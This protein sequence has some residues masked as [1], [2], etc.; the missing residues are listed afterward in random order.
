MVL[1]PGEMHELAVGRNAID[2]GIAVVE[3]AVQLAECRDLRRT[4]ESEVLGPEE[5]HFPLALVGPVVDLGE[6]LLGVGGDH[7]LEVEGRE[8]V[9]NGKHL[10]ST[11]S[12]RKLRGWLCLQLDGFAFIIVQIYNSCLIDRNRRWEHAH[13]W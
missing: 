5:D 10:I 2:H 1:P 8:L 3:L 12:L 7:R 4:D 9:T 6:G 11:P 13:A